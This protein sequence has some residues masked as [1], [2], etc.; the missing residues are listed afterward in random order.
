MCLLPDSMSQSLPIA[1]AAFIPLPE[2]ER[3][4]YDCKHFTG[5]LRYFKLLSLK[6]I[7]EA[8]N[9]PLVSANDGLEDKEHFY[10]H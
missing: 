4:F 5:G 7:S 10:H 2:K 1:K 9:Q 6:K 8:I 3:E